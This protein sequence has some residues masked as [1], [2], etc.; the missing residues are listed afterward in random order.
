MKRFGSLPLV[1]QPGERWLYNSDSDI[2]GVLISRV[3]GTSLEEFLREQIFVPLGMNDIG[4]AGDLR[5]GRLR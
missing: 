1:H 4:G 2:L 5:A 3:V